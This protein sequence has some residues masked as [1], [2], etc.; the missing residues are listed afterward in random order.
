MVEC[1]VAPTTATDNLRV[2]N[3]QR[4]IQRG[5][6]ICKSNSRC[7]LRQGQEKDD[8]RSQDKT[9]ISPFFVDLRLKKVKALYLASSLLIRVSSTGLLLTRQLILFRFYLI[10]STISSIGA[11]DSVCPSLTFVK[12]PR[13]MQQKTRLHKFFRSCATD[14]NRSCFLAGEIHEV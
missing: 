13:N 2:Q 11:V 8:E 5:R 4:G 9:I 12:A 1:R 10:I 6:Q 14:H 7:S 3:T